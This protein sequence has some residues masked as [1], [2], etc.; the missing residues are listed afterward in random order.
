MAT[1]FQNWLMQ[2]NYPGVQDMTP[3]M[4]SNY[5]NQFQNKA[6]LPTIDMS[7]PQVMKASMF[8]DISNINW[9]GII[10]G[11]KNLFGFGNN[12]P[13]TDLNRP[14]LDAYQR[15]PHRG[16]GDVTTPPYMFQDMT[17]DEER[18]PGR[19]QEELPTKQGFNLP[20]FGLTGIL[21]GLGDK[22]KRSPEN[23]AAYEAITAS[24]GDKGW[25]TY[26]GNPYQLRDGKIYSD[27]DPYG[28]HADSFFGS[29]SIEAR[30][31]KK[32][33]WA[34]DRLDKFKDDEDN[35]G[36]SKRL[37]DVLVNRGIIDESGTRV[38]TPSAVDEVIDKTTTWTP[39]AGTGDRI[40]STYTGPQT[41]DYSPSQAAR[42][43]HYTERPG[44]QGGY[45]DPGKDSYG[46]WKAEGGR[47]GYRDGELVD[48]DINIAGPG[49]D[50]NEN[51]EMASAP[52]PMA[53][54]EAFSL[55][56]FKKS[57]D[58]LNDEE[59]DILFEM[60]NDQAAVGQGEG[61]ASLV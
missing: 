54:L 45:I 19:V 58:K 35:L 3:G 8:P 28:S 59:R 47:A 27:L 49:F 57:F 10:E 4:Y 24:Q 53:E 50:F 6:E 21:Q 13:P 2:N 26:K 43:E 22:F 20:N 60:M 17:V 56:I 38:I 11:G 16:F 9:S 30:D 37:F 51:I 36:I 52:D 32:I 14:I 23:Q 1:A 40:Q 18:I 41:Y 44:T 5:S 29:K 42:T 39:D 61:I 46:P 12:E 55:Q 34:L 48:E 7:N 33:D 31:Q 25:G 15:S